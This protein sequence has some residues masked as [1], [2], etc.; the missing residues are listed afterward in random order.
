MTAKPANYIPAVREQYE[1]FPYPDRKP[2]EEKVRL[3]SGYLMRLDAVSHHCYRGAQNFQ[4]FR[5][6][7][8]GGGTGDAVVAWAEQLRGL[9]KSEVVYL[10]MSTTSMQI[11]KK[12]ADVR[13]LDNIKWINDS[14]LNIPDLN[15][16]QFDFIDCTGVLHHLKEPD[17]GLKTLK[18]ALK[19]GGA[20]NLMVYAPYGRT[21]IYHMQNL[22]RLINEDEDSATRK[23]IN[24]KAAL[25]SLPP[26]HLLRIMGSHGI[27][28]NDMKNDAGIYDMFLHAQDRP[29]NIMEVHDWL[30][31]CGL[32]MVSEPG[33]SNLQTH[34]EPETFIKDEKLLR[35]I[36][37]YPLKIRQG[38]GEALSTKITMHEFYCTHAGGEDRTA[39][40]TDTHLVPWGGVDPK[41]SFDQIA[42]VAEQNKKDVTITFNHRSDKPS[43]GIPYGK[44]IPDLLRLIDGKRSIAEI[45]AALKAIP[46]FKDYKGV[47]ADIAAEFARLFTLLNRAHNLY[48]REKSVEPFTS[49]VELSARVAKIK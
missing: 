8:A 29:Y 21:G 48:L 10:D 19:P 26:N 23:I 2:E 7:I 33:V 3:L 45:Y 46:G 18:G 28:F 20:M 6:L 32:E 13:R 24:T 40:V 35:Y 30:E 16:G 22:M 47:D 41:A 14:L 42:T 39:R 25:A 5:V 44:F 4:D 36:A 11:A 43:M 15:L 1:E 9:G 17:L 27:E 49:L 34:Y 12:R 31:R 38:I 37:D